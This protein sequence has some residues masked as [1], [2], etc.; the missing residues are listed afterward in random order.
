MVVTPR[1]QQ[2]GSIGADTIASELIDV[3]TALDIQSE[4]PVEKIEKLV[5]TAERMCFLM[6]AIRKP[7]AVT[8]KVQLNGENIGA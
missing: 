7:H 5:K 2:T 3:E 6:D 4:A 1:F 8:A